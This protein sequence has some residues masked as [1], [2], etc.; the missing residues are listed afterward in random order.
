MDQSP[1]GERVSDAIALLVGKRTIRC[2]HPGCRVS[3][4]YSHVTPDEAR[5]LTGIAT[6]HTRH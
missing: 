4:R 6:D 5:R 1:L 2:P 3:V